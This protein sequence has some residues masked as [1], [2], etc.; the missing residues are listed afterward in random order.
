MY[1]GDADSKLVSIEQD[2]RSVHRETY[3]PE[4]S[5]TFLKHIELRKRYINADGDIVNGMEAN[6]EESI[7]ARFP[8]VCRSPRTWHVYREVTGTWEDPI[9]SAL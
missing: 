9:C 2:A 3:R 1:G 6:T 8:R 7:K 5:C 4:G